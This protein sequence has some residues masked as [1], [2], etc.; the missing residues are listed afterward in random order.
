[1]SQIRLHSESHELVDEVMALSIRYGIIT[2]YTSFPMEEP[3]AALT[4]AGRE[5]IVRRETERLV[6]TST[7][8][9]GAR[10]VDWAQTHGGAESGGAAAAFRQGSGR[11]R[12]IPC[13]P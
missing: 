4:R 1:M 6:A 13:M 9:A 8:V 12:D 10:V 5:E 7:A 3:A 11:E 2:P